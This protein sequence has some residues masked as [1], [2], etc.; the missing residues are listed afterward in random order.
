MTIRQLIIILLILSGATNAFDI[1]Y[2]LLYSSDN[3]TVGHLTTVTGCTFALSH[4]FARLGCKQAISLF[5]MVFVVSLFFESLGVATGLVYGPY[6]YSDRLGPKFLGLVPYLIPIAWFMM[7][8]PAYVLAE[9]LAPRNWRGWQADLVISALCGVLM[10]AWDLVMDP[11]KILV[12][13]WVWE[14]NGYYFGIPIQN[15][16]GWWLT[17]FG[18]IASFR[19]L[20]RQDIPK[21]EAAF[22]RLAWIA[23]VLIA[24]GDTLKALLHGLF[25]PALVGIFALTPWVAMGWVR[26]GKKNE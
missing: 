9:R 14:V 12:G 16:W 2:F 15:Y 5:G 17:V 26:L 8:Y 25:G 23:F 22:D 21:P 18:A 3:P 24:Y 13:S 7:V 10:A 20:V 19:L 4:A 11:L 6:H 1:L